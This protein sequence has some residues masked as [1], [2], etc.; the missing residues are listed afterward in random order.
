MDVNLY[1]IIWNDLRALREEG[2]LSLKLCNALPIGLPLNM[3]DSGLVQWRS[4]THLSGTK[5]CHKLMN[6]FIKIKEY[7]GTFTISSSI[8]RFLLNFCVMQS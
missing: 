8:C 4:V 7:I 5:I 3:E 1:F 2:S 6:I